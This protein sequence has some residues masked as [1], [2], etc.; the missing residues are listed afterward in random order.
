MP[1]ARPRGGDERV[2]YVVVR[3][4]GAGCG[5]PIDYLDKLLDARPE[6][7]PT[8]TPT[9]PPA[10]DTMELKRREDWDDDY[11]SGMDGDEP[12]QPVGTLP[13]RRRNCMLTRA[14]V[15]VTMTMT[16]PQAQATGVALGAESPTETIVVNVPPPPPPKPHHSGMSPTTEHLLIAAGSIGE[17]HGAI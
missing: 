6:P 2:D 15:F 4:A 12:S 7:E 3:R 14:Q 10:L 5:G 9:Q 8:P 11:D 13:M 17:H 1:V 16:L